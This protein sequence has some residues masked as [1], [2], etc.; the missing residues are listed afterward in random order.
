MQELS[1]I[2]FAKFINKNIGQIQSV[3]FQ[4]YEDGL[5]SGISDNYLKVYVPGKKQYVNKI[6]NVELLRYDNFIFGKL[7]D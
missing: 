4:K 3:L 6:F 5:L 1:D 2:L 7:I